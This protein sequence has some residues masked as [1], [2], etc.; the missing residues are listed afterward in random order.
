[1]TRPSASGPGLPTSRDRNGAR[2]AREREKQAGIV[3]VAA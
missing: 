3:A 2:C 1:M